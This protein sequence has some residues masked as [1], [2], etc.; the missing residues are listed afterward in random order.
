MI[1]E[2]KWTKMNCKISGSADSQGPRSIVFAHCWGDS[3]I[4]FACLQPNNTV[5]LSEGLQIEAVSLQDTSWPVKGYWR[6]E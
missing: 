1:S 6:L 4:V 2:S 3:I 5:S